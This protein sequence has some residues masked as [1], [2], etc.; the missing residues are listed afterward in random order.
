MSNLFIPSD[1]L[2]N[3]FNFIVETRAA[4][5]DWAQYQNMLKT[6]AIM[7]PESRFF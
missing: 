6:V 1:S 3:I 4:E 5:L 7:F 2:R